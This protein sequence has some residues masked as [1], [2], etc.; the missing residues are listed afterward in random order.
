MNSKSFLVAGVVATAALVP[1]AFAAIASPA[2]LPMEKPVYV[3]G[4]QAACTGAGAG[5]RDEPRWKNY[6]VRFEAV[7]GYG[8]YLGNELLTVKKR[9]DATFVQVS[10]AAPWVLMQLPADNYSATM[11]VAGADHQIRFTVDPNHQRDLIV[12]FPLKLA[13]E[14]ATRHIASNERH[15][16][17]M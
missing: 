17:S 13:G 8:Q 11:H 2:H 9:G 10:C 16:T 14:P 4:V 5:E 7:G 3:A 1:P 6:D 12:R 15:K